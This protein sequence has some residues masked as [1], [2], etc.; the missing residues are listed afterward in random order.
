MDG[1]RAAMR[2]AGAADGTGVRVS[3][4]AQHQ[5]HLTVG[6]NPWFVRYRPVSSLLENRSGSAA[7]FAVVVAVCDA[8]GVDVLVDVVI[9]HMI[10]AGGGGAGHRRHVLLRQQLHLPGQLYAGRLSLLRQRSWGCADSRPVRLRRSLPG[11]Q[12]RTVRS[13]RYRQRR[14]RSAHDVDRLP[15]KSHSAMRLRSPRRTATFR[16]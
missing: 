4:P 3:S 1:R 10:N 15:A 8:A 12:L 6:G 16:S 2:V 14:S 9:N 7:Q 11:A 13:G 5:S